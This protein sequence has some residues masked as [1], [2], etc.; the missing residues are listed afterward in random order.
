MSQNSTEITGCHGLNSMLKEKIYIGISTTG[1]AGIK[2][3]KII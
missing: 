3:E 1:I 2:A